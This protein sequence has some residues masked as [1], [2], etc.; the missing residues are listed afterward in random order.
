M[1]HLE[2]HNDMDVLAGRIELAKLGVSSLYNHV[3]G[4]AL[5]ESVVICRQIQRELHS[6]GV[7][8]APP[9]PN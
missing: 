2:Q 5:T 9:I 3:G 8:D 1:Y 6:D 4:V 7:C